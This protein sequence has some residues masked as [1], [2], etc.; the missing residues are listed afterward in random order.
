MLPSAFGASIADAEPAINQSLVDAEETLFLN[1]DPDK[2]VWLGSLIDKTDAVGAD[3]KLYNGVSYGTHGVTYLRPYLF[4]LKRMKNP[5]TDAWAT[6]GRLLCLYDNAGEH[7]LPGQDSAAMPV[8][9]HMALSR[10]LL[11]LY[12]P[13]QDPRFRDACTRAGLKVPKVERDRLYRQETTLTEAA[14]RVKK[15]AGM[16]GGHVADRM[17]TVVVSKYDT[18]EPLLGLP[19][20]S[21]P[22]RMSANGI[23]V[24]DVDR[25]M[26]LSTALRG[27]LAKLCPEIVY[28]AEGFSQDVTYLPVSSLGPNTEIEQQTG[29]LAIRPKNVEPIGVTLPFLYAIHR[30]APGLIPRMRRK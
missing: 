10:A 17:L 11:F 30:S 7:F 27:L 14:A 6:R 23:G 15:Y 1:A 3:Q 19:K 5:A 28:A 13:T 26:A 4:T 2:P 24:L 9:R 16:A 29:K 21:D 8:A 22:W 12:D 18:W 20:D 25:V